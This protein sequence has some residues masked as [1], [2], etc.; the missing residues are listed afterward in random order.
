MPLTLLLVESHD[1]IRVALTERLQRMPGISV[2][3][4]VPDVAAA[5]QMSRQL[6]LDIVLYEPRTVQED[7]RKGLQVLEATGKPIV[8]LVASLLPGEATALRMAG[9]AA[10]LL[11]DT[12]LSPLLE[13]LV[14][15]AGAG[16]EAT[17]LT[18]SPW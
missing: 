10:V 13:A 4:A 5:V 17:E 12:N 7:V 1:Q 16:Y 9:A 15:A 2:V 11:K 18:L 8:V 3:G 14:M 6:A